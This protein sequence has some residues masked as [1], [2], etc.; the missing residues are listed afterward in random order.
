MRC[1]EQYVALGENSANVAEIKDI[2]EG[3][4]DHSA[5]LSQFV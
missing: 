2:V 3:T 4:V 1:L 5:E